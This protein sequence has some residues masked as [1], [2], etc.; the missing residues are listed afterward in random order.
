MAITFPSSP[1]PGDIFTS[2]GKS[3]QY[4]N[5]KWESYGETVAPDVF[6]VDA[7][8]DV[9]NVY[10]SLSAGASASIAGDLAVDTNTLV[11]DSTNNSVGIGTTTPTSPLHIKADSF[12]M[13]SLDRTDNANVDQQVVLTPTYSGSGN[14]AF[15]IK[16]GSEIMRVTEEGRV[17][18]GTTAPSSPLNVVHTNLSAEPYS[19]IVAKNTSSTGTAFTGFTAD[20]VYQSHYRYALNGSLKW[21][22]RVGAGN[23]TDDFRI[24]SWTAGTDV[25]IADSGGRVRTPIQTSWRVGLSSNTTYS[26]GSNTVL[27]NQTSGNDCHITN[28]TLASGRI[29]VPATGTY[30]V[31]LLLRTESTTG[32]NA[33]G[34]YLRKNGT[35]FTRWYQTTDTVSNFHHYGPLI[36]TVKASANDYFDVVY[37][38]SNSSSVLSSAAN[39]V[40]H[41]SGYLLG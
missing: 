5:G 36:T 1:S 2:N 41:F 35:I 15:A 38:P 30:V 22:T 17:G 37:I 14:T 7:A 19:A 25:M 20:S 24:Y 29:T 16:I 28:C 12:D 33:T 18:I 39:T 11:V 6:A 34:V 4:V 8:N 13:L 32:G 10:G 27:W 3:W 9:V 23:G 26:A 31:A 21:Q 40:C